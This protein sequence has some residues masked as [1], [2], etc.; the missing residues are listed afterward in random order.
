MKKIMIVV[1]AFLAISSFAIAQTT[2]ATPASKC[3]V[4]DD[5]WCPEVTELTNA[6][7]VSATPVVATAAEYPNNPYWNPQDLDYASVNS[8]VGGQ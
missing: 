2:P 6:T 7:A 5:G 8:S 3:V 4:V 1:T